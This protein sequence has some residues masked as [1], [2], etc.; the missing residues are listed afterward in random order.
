MIIGSEILPPSSIKSFHETLLPFKEPRLMSVGREIPKLCLATVA[1]IV[2]PPA[3]TAIRLTKGLG[4]KGSF[5]LKCTKPDQGAPR[6][7][8]GYS[9]SL[10]FEKKGEYGLDVYFFGLKPVSLFDVC[11]DQK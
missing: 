11:C 10:A 5:C 6:F 3:E 1:R 7:A 8:G 4:K 2:S 9:R